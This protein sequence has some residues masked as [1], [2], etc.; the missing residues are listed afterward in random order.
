MGYKI[1]YS[2]S[3]EKYLTRLTQSKA[4]SVLKRI[5]FVATNPFKPDNNIVK[6]SGTVSSYRL[7]IG[8]IRVIYGLDVENKIIYVVK[9]SPRGSVYS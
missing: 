3:A 2:P 1:L 8:D 4:S 5:Q 6:L 9:I 7:R